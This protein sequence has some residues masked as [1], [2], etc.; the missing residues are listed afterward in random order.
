MT[1]HTLVDTGPLVAWFNRAER[2]H[3]WAVTQFKR[4]K[5]P[6]LTCEAVLTEACFLLRSG[7][8]DPAVALDAVRRG[9]VK[10]DFSLAAEI[11]P[12]NRLM[13]RYANIGASLADVCLVRMSELHSNCKVLTLDRDF[14]IYRRD[15][16]RTIPLIA[17]FDA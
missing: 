9:A 5:P 6:L 11:E 13:R 7:R 14:L 12:V 1:A 16:R 8:I 15:G 4:L 3:E 10:L 2:H 17:P